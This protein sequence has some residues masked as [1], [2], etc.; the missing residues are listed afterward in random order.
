[1]RC[2][3]FLTTTAPPSPS[4]RYL[5]Q[6]CCIDGGGGQVCTLLN[7]PSLTTIGKKLVLTN[8]ID[9]FDMVLIWRKLLKFQEKADT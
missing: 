7:H 5:M 1:M 6:E 9:R 3:Y 8:D 2:F 4:I